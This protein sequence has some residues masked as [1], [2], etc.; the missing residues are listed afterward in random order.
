VADETAEILQLL[1]GVQTDNPRLYQAL[2]QLTETVQN[3]YFQLNPLVTQSQLTPPVD[4][5]V[6]APVSFNYVFTPTTVRFTWSEVAGTTQY[7][8][9]LGSNWDTAAF[10][11][12][13]VSLQG[14]IDALLIGTY[15]YLIKSITQAGIYSTTPTALIVTVPI[16]PQVAINFQV[17]DNN[18]LLFWDEPPSSFVIDFYEVFR[19]GLSLGILGGTFFTRFE[20]TSGSF[21]Y[22]VIATDIAGNESVPA[23]VTLSV[24]NPPDFQLQDSRVSDFSGTKDKTI[25]YS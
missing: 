7:E 24:N 3:I 2:T 15:T 21:E 14:D 23:F 9:R 8:I 10:V 22:G 20:T 25:A 11:F 4:A 18:I 1:Q 16:I 19:D 13:S 17:I 12:R 5:P 6:I